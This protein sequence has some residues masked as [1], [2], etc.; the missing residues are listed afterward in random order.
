[1]FSSCSVLVL[2]SGSVAE[3]DSPQALLKRPE[4]L[5]ASLWERHQ[6]STNGET[7]EQEEQVNLT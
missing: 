1:M 3:F 6:K 5:F 7:T 2:E 4:G